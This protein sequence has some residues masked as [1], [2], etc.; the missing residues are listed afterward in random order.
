[1]RSWMR[2][3]D[4]IFPYWFY[5]LVS[6]PGTMHFVAF[7][8]CDY[9]QTP[10][11]DHIKPEVLADFVMQH[12]ADMNELCQKLGETEEEIA[13]LSKEIEACFYG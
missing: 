1:V 3:L 11:G 12:F 9:V 7:S 2:E 8:L 5:F 10:R 4:L 13:K 6:K